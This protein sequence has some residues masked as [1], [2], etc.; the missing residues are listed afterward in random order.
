[1]AIQT[2][3]NQDWARFHDPKGQIIKPGTTIHCVDEVADFIALCSTP[4]PRPRLK[5]AGSH[6][7]L[8]TATVSDA[9]SIETHWPGT[10]NVPLNSGFAVDMYD[11]INVAFFHRMA[12]NPPGKPEDLIQDPCLPTDNQGFF[13]VH[14]KSGTRIFDTY[15]LLDRS[16][17]VVT[18]LARELNFKLDGGHNAGAY[19]GPWAFETLGGAGGQTV[20]GALTTGTHG[21]DYRQKPISDTVM[22]LHLVTDGG[23]HC[24]VE[25]TTNRYE[26][27]LTDDQKLK[28]HY[29]DVVP[30]ANFRIIR[31]DDIFNSITVGCGRFGVVTSVVLRVVPQYC[32]HEHRRLEQWS[33]VKALLRQSGHHAFDRVHFSSANALADRV[34]F[35]E[36][37]GN[38]Q[39][40]RN[41]FLQIAVDLS[42]DGRNE[43]LCGVTQRWFYPMVGAE[44]HDPTG[45][46]RGRKERGIEQVVGKCG[47][48]EPPE[49][50]SKAGGNSTFLSRACSNG[51][52]VAGILRG[53]A[54]EIEQIVCDGAVPAAGAVAAA[55]AIGAGAA[56]AAIAGLCA[57]LAAAAAL[58]KHLADEMEAAGDVSFAQVIDAGIKA[59]IDSPLPRELAIMLIRTIFNVVF[60]SQQSDRDFVAIS[61]AV[62][63]THDYLD[64]SCY[65][66][67]ESI[68]V[69]FDASQP[70]LYCAYVDEILS[71]EAF[72]QE[73]MGRFSAGYVSLR[74]VRGSDALIAPSRFNETVVI[75]VAALREAA[76]SVDFVMNA[77]KVARKP[78]FNASF[79]WGQFNPLGRGEIERQFSPGNRLERWRK[80][81]R[82]LTNNGAN[83]SFSND[84]TRRTGLEPF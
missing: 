63:D 76:G 72:Q 10:Q 54:E 19:D 47:S 60:R 37:F 81:L 4:A 52:F 46:I 55:L 83:D 13:L 50:T 24:W 38:E 42:P 69:F 61:Y 23:D 29:R 36:R 51:N 66:N 64:R 30:S 12:D 28:E 77:A 67:A 43:R 68:E 6:W 9:N 32:L 80:S 14:L 33:T 17:D 44:S 74:Y 78:I 49:D 11:L 1:M 79:H 35:H 7:A 18:S 53:L 2:L 26:I 71:F 57:L 70:S 15:S 22:A 73:Q 41:R 62:M 21:G 56:V 3:A 48:Y 20:F 27:Q 40:L 75:E 16:P 5:A 84:F 25:P 59:V 65:G 39:I 34:A 45:N 8:S 31:N 58:L 82:E